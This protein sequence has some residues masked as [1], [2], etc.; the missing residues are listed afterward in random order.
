VR[1]RHLAYFLSFSEEA[2]QHFRTKDQIYWLNLVDVE[3][4]NIRLALEWS[5]GG[6][7]VKGMRLASALKWFWHICARYQDGEI[8]INRLFSLEAETRGEVPFAAGNQSDTYLRAWVQCVNAMA[9]IKANHPVE[10]T[11]E[12]IRQLLEQA[13]DLCRQ[14]GP[15]ANRDLFWSVLYQADPNSNGEPLR[16][17]ALQIARENH[18]RFE[19]SE[20]LFYEWLYHLYYSQ[21]FEK[22]AQC[23]EPSLAIVKELQDVDGMA[24]RLLG[25]VFLSANSGDLNRA[26]NLYDE[27]INYHK[28]VNNYPSVHIWEIAFLRFCQDQ[29]IIQ[30]AEQALQ[31]FEEIQDLQNIH[32][33]Y[34]NLI[35]AE[36][37][38]CNLPQAKQ[39]ADHVVSMLHSNDQMTYFVPFLL[40]YAG[41]LA[42]FSGDYQ[43]ARYQLWKAGSMIPLYLPVNMESRMV[44]LEILSVYRIRSGDAVKGAKILGA[45]DPTLK[46]YLNISFPWAPRLFEEMIQSARLALGEEAFRAAW[47]E[48]QSMAFE[49]AFDT[50]LEEFLRAAEQQASSG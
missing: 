9:V 12:Q 40:I 43:K 27:G 47:V 38:N 18:F 48:G 23:M 32:H 14:I 33:G 30:Q 50:F 8:W 11:N 6:H 20:A 10:I 35:Q 24:A 28:Q 26:R 44:F 39:L 49:Q 15:S 16:E 31:Y 36:W 13:A 17:K 25:S 41:G 45:L 3:L 5:F 4:D 21:D 1:D 42:V 7:L 2:E 37:S 22:G 19:E 29:P 34:C 46:R